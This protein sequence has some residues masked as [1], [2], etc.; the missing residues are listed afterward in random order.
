MNESFPL[1]V[2]CGVNFGL[3][4][5]V[6]SAIKPEE[7]IIAVEK[8]FHVINVNIFY[9]VQS[10]EFSKRGN[11]LAPILREDYNKGPLL[12]KLTPGSGKPP[13]GRTQEGAKT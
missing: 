13:E 6:L 5:F 4:L 3:I 12:H 11:I 7:Q 1:N 8:I 10:F 2:Q 9:V